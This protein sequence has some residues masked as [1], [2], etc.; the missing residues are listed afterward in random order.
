MFFK[1]TKNGNFSMKLLF[2]AM[3]QSENIVFPYKL[4]WNSWVP[5]KVGFFFAWEAS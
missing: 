1:E 2:K 4:I 5:M 3:D